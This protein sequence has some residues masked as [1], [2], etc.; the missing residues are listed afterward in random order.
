MRTAHRRLVGDACKTLA[1]IVVYAGVIGAFAFAALYFVPAG[2]SVRRSLCHLQ[3]TL[4]FGAT[5]IGS[6]PPCS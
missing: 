5:P 4:T 1:G 3:E 2:P 6:S